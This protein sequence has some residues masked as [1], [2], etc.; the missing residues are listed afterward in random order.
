MAKFTL[1]DGRML[2]FDDVG[3]PDGFP[4]VYQ[5]WWMH[6][7]LGR[8]PDDSLAADAGLRLVS[9]DRPG[10]GGSTPLAVRTMRGSADDTEQLVDHLGIDRFALLG[11]SG[12][13]LHALAAAH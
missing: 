13:G 3:N 6:G 5:S 12:G 9:V 7:R 8:H 2:A 11:R 10:Y 4:V 1:T